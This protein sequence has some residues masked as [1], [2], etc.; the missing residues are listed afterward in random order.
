MF[1]VAFSELLIIGVVALIV[2]GP[3]RLPTV[4]RT[5]GVMLGRL[6]RYVANVKADINREM[7][8]DELRKLQ[9]ELAETARKLESGMATGVANAQQ[10]LDDAA[11]TLRATVSDTSPPV[12]P[13][14]VA[15]AS[16]VPA[17][18]LSQTPVASPA[19]PVSPLPASPAP[20][21]SAAER[22]D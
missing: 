19:A 20:A 13:E 15:S 8:L 4:A 18:T 2:I 7:Q 14:T 11:Q 6:Q 21:I 10:A 16:S 12:P 1:D 22:K 3:R 17:D 5:L 9:A